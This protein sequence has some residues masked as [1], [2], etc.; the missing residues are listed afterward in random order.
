MAL[1]D[2]QP[3]PGRAITVRP[4]AAGPAQW[5][6]FDAFR[7][8]AH[9]GVDPDGAVRRILANEALARWFGDDATA[10][11]VR[12]VLTGA[13]VSADRIDEAVVVAEELV[14]HYDAHGDAAGRLR[15]LGELVTARFARGEFERAL[16]EL[17][18]ALVT[19][20]RLESQGVAEPSA[21]VVVANAASVAELFEI[22]SS[23]LRRCARLPQ[24]SVFLVRQAD[25]VCARNDLRWGNRLE[26]MGEL[27]AATARFR[28]A[29]RFAMRIQ[30]GELTGFWR[31]VGRLC[32]G[33]A[34]AALDEPELALPAL[35]EGCEGDPRS[36]GG[37]D[38]LILRL[39]LARACS[40]LGRVEEARHHLEVAAG[41][42]DPSFSRQWHI[43]T[44]LY[45]AEVERCRFG[46]H[47]GLDYARHAAALLAHALWRE[48][49]RRLENVMVR[50]QMLE[51]A[52]ENERV[53]HEA[54]R[55]ALTGLANRR[56]LDMALEALAK[57]DTVSS[58]LFVDLDDF[59]TTNDSFSHTVGDEVL[60]SIA[61]ILR[62]ECRE[63]DVVA[64]FG[65]DEFVLVLHGAPRKTGIRVG[66]R[67]RSAVKAFSW[68]KIA[69]DLRVSVSI[70]VAE[71]QPGMDLSEALLTAD[72]ALYAAKQ[73]GRDRVAAA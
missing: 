59:K 65:G 21:F 1:R 63:D 43:T 39:A 50:M 53:E 45:A 23:Y 70:G 29:L 68:E 9:C 35:L 49:E 67:I 30:Q 58:L 33:A 42:P 47:P 11:Q 46:D 4:T 13:L 19:L 25:A 14:A 10:W 72:S 64:R 31:R 54:L 17:I 36:V 66:E 16:D 18:D 27:D 7:A 38:A 52:A 61:A 6:V 69:P 73:Q 20:S 60:R 22:A 56:A 48:R 51:L 34:W 15:A 37:E 71:F 57:S 26:L 40:S 24:P 32:E 3:A 2:D 8:L 55:D 5:L 44:S 12:E 62:G 41:L 28:E